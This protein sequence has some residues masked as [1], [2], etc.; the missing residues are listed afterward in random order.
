VKSALP[1]PTVATVLRV[2]AVAVVVLA[3]TAARLAH[4]QEEA[5][6]APDAALLKQAE[7]IARSSAG[8]AAAAQADERGVR[9]EVQVGKLDPRLKLAP[10]AKIEPYLPAGAPAWGATRVGLR[11]LEGTRR[12]NVALPVTVHVFARAT[13]VNANLGAGT[14]LEAGELAEAEV[15]LAAAPGAALRDADQA[16]G[17]TLLRSLGAGSPLR[18]SDLKP[19]QYFAAGETVRVVALGTGWQV[20]TE[21]QAMNPGVEGQTARVRTESGRILNARPTG[22]REVELTL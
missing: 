8:T 14:V 10:C 11:C 9:V 5:T 16:V 1:R 22:D 2:V 3:A 17:R 18:Q 4:A 20:V 13:V 15:D 7:A 19:R 21:G 12:W 6:W